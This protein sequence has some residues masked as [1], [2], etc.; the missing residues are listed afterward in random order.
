MKDEHGNQIE[1]HSDVDLILNGT[2]NKVFIQENVGLDLFY[3]PK[4]RIECGSNN[5]IF[6][7]RN[8]TYG[9]DC[10]IK[11]GN[12]CVVYMGED[13][14]LSNEVQL[15]CSHKNI[16]IGNHVWLGLRTTVLEGTIISDGSI[17]GAC[18][19]TDTKY[20]NNCILVGNPAQIVRKNAAWHRSRDERNMTAINESYRQVTRE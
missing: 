16:I 20:P 4:I 15:I 3:I 7:D 11:C 18:A 2:N 1:L 13:C 5:L 12:G 10:K 14:M 17:L 19:V 9:K 8:V 6:I